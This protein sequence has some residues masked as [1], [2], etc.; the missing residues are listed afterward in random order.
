MIFYFSATGN[1]KQIANDLTHLLEGEELCSITEY[2][3]KVPITASTIGFVFPTY[4][5]GIPTCIEKFIH[6]LNI[7]G[8]PYIY[9]IA[10]C[11][12]SHGVSLH[13]IDQLLKH[14]GLMLSSGFYII[15]PENYIISYNVTGED[16]QK[17]QFANA[18]S[19]LN[20]ITKYIKERKSNKLKRG[21]YI[22]DGLIGTQVNIHYRK[23]FPTMDKGFIVNDR[24]IGCGLCSQVCQFDNIQL[25]N[26]R[27]TWGH[28]CE[29]CLACIHHC[30][31]HAIDWKNKTQ[32]R[33]RYLN[34]NI[35]C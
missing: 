31:A 16:Q 27:P 13:Q 35:K 21:R 9:A 32:K 20:H 10:T 28:H 22:I 25:I 5:W 29:F 14:K 15:M 1:S 2:D 24:C 26:K 4:F 17:K 33:T 30:K 34:P 8:N 12:G 6:S 7:V 19:Q 3:T 11:G 23:L 18:Q